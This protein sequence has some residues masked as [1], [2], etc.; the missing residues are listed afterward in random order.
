M[1]CSLFESNF[2]VLETLAGQGR[3][4]DGCIA[5]LNLGHWLTQGKSTVIS[6]KK[7]KNVTQCG[8]AYVFNHN[9]IFNYDS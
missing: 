8:A 2:V 3:S 4:F 9:A 1:N 6:V 7:Y 5:T